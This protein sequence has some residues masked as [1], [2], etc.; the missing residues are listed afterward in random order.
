MK[1]NIIVLMMLIYWAQIDRQNDQFN[2]TDAV[3]IADDDG[4]V[5]ETTTTKYSIFGL[6]L[7][8]L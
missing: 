3:K 6:E 2:Q 1:I 4:F 7:V 5:C 8:F